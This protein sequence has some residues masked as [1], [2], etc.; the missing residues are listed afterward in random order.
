MF[1]LGIETLDV[2]Y[3]E[4]Y[5]DIYMQFRNYNSTHK[6]KTNIPLKVCARDKWS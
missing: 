2:N 3:G 1:A 6:T 4:R 5:F